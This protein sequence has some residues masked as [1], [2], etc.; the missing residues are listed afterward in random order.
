ML[1]APKQD[2]ALYERRSRDARREW[3]RG[4]TPQASFELYEDLVRFGRSLMTDRDEAARREAARWREK[5]A[6]RATLR[7]A[8][9]AL[10]GAR[11]G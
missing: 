10:D 3:L 2:W 8:C 1:E 7:H 6:I 9:L 11:D 4:L 5:L